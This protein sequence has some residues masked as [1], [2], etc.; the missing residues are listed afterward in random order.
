MMQ[1]IDISNLCAHPACV[2]NASLT[3]IQTEILKANVYPET[4]LLN[5]SGK[6]LMIQQDHW[7]ENTNLVCYI[8]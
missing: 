1:T 2:V 8:N 3:L 7:L 5:V 6:L 4:L